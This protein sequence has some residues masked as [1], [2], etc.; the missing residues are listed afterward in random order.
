MNATFLNKYNINTVT[1]W[2]RIFYLTSLI[3]PFETNNMGGFL[4]EFLEGR[5]LRTLATPFTPCLRNDGT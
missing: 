2:K 5:M 4:H 3:I 1:G